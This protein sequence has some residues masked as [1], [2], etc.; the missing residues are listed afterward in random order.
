MLEVQ[1]ALKLLDA[2]NQERLRSLSILSPATQHLQLA[3][4][5]ENNGKARHQ[6]F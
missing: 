3:A 1:T 6:D 4:T 2:S 5:N